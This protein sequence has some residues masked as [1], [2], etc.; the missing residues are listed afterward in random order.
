[1]FVV[2]ITVLC[3]FGATWFGE[4]TAN[5]LDVQLPVFSISKD[6]AEQMEMINTGEGTLFA[7]VYET[8]T[9]FV[10]CPCTVTL[11][12]NCTQ[13]QITSLDNTYW[14][15]TKGENTVYIFA[16]YKPPQERTCETE[17]PV[18]NARVDICISSTS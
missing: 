2:W 18:T 4:Y 11:N 3:V 6:T 1:M 5:H 10:A 9:G 8:K 7:A 16:S 14:Y 17:S 15:Y 12:A 13:W